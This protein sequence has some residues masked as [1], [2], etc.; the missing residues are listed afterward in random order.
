MGLFKSESEQAKADHD[1]GQKEG[2]RA[3]WLEQT[4]HDTIDQSLRSDDYNKGWENGVNNQPK[5]D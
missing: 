3:G 1:E 2:S 4:F 5:D